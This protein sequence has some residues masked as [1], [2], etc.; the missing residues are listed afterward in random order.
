[1]SRLFKRDVFE[2]SPADA[3][4]DLTD[5]GKFHAKMYIVYQSVAYVGSAKLTQISICGKREKTE[6]KSS[7]N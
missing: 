3:R 7:P 1:M 5:S 6:V 2:I 4:Y